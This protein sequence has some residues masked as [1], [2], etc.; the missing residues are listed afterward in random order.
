MSHESVPAPLDMGPE[1]YDALRE[2]IA[3]RYPGL[4]RRLQQVARFALDH[5][6]DLAL[7]T[8]ATISGRIGVQPSTIIRFAKSFRFSGFSE[9]QRIFQSALLE[10]VPGYSGRLP[11]PLRRVGPDASEEAL[12]ILQE[13]CVANTASLKHLHDMPLAVPLRQAIALLARARI[14]HVLGLRR[15]FPAAAY[16]AYALGHSGQQTHLLSGTAGMLSEQAQLVGPDDVVLVVS[17]FPYAQETVALVEAVAK[18]DVPILAITDSTISPLARQAAVCF[19][20][21]DAE[22][23]GFRSMSA[24]MCLAQTLVVG[25]NA[26]LQ[27]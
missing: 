5:P 3:Q 18:R 20:I 2:E 11:Q 12:Q 7:D 4:S 10:Q 9:M 25:L 17:A 6:N 19:T 13:V 26:Q 23:R 21:H 14:I 27:R 15:S 24:S 22:L 16:L 8:V 1:N